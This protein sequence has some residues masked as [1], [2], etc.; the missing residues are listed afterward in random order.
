[1]AMRIVSAREVK[2]LPVGTFVWLRKGNSWRASKYKI[3]EEHGVKFLLGTN[4]RLIKTIKK[5]PAFHYEIR[6]T[7]KREPAR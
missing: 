5:D 6:D 2:Q 3:V 7:E 1:M 4:S